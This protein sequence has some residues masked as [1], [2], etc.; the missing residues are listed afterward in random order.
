MTILLEKY[1]GQMNWIGDLYNI[2]TFKRLKPTIDEIS[3][4]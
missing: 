3:P 2:I 4:E 1:L